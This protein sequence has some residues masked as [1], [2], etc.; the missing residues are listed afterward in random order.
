MKLSKTLLEIAKKDLEAAKCL[1]EKELYPQAIFY[2]QQSVEK[3]A[4]SF[5][6]MTNMIKE[7]EV[8]AVWHY[9]P[10][11]R[12]DPKVKGNVITQGY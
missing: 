3:A 4:K 7:D 10:V 8:K 11:P 5:A 1:Y 2:L 6:I 9:P 12:C